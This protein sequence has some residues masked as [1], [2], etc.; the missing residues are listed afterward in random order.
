MVVSVVVSLVRE[1]LDVYESELSLLDLR[2]DFVFKAFFGNER[3][4]HLLLQFLNAILG[5]A[6]KSVTLMDPNVE[7]THA[8]DK[9]FRYGSSCRNESWGT[10]QH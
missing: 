8:D 10:N 2:N 9:S 4:N 5:N 1:E 3:N 6:I 7:P